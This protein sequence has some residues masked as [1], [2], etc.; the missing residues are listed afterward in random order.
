MRT[1]ISVAKEPGFIWYGYLEKSI[2]GQ[3]VE[4]DRETIANNLGWLTAHL[5]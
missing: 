3:T 4:N 2:P 1:Y 5:F